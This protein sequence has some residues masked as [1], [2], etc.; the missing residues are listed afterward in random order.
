[1]R[2]WVA[3]LLLSASAMAQTNRGSISGTVFDPTSSVIAGAHVT[4]TSTGTNEA[5]KLTTSESGTYSLPN[6]DP[7]TYRVEVEAPG[8]KKKV[9]DNVKVDTA[10]NATVNVTM[11]TGSVDTS[12]TVSAD[13]GLVN[14]ESGTTSSTI[15]EREIRDVPLVNRSVLGLALTLPNVSGDAGSENPGLTAGTSCP[16]CTLSVGGGV[17]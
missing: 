14:T 12:V 2:F 9:V 8:F 17:R 5:H 15:T 3:L 10:S 16:C 4:I 1:M 6:L 13:A 11:E 7:V